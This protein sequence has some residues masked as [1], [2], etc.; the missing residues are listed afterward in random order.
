MTMIFLQIEV[1]KAP[2]SLAQEIA[3]EKTAG[4]KFIEAK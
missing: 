2:L 4:W 3:T 1:K